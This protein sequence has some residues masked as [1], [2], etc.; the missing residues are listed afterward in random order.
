LAS[1]TTKRL[2]E[3]LK[4]LRRVHGV[5]QE[6]FAEAAN[7]GYKYYQAIEQ[8]RKTNLRLSTLDRLANAYGIEVWE[9]LAP[10]LP[11]TKFA[12]RIR[13]QKDK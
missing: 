4:G 2:I 13:K 6:A 9:L 1:S 10:T 7:L 5:N 8:G 12:K 11:K 3:R